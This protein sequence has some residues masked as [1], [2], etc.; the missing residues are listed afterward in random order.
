MCHWSLAIITIITR[1]FIYISTFCDHF[2]VLNYTFCAPRTIPSSARFTISVPLFNAPLCSPETGFLSNFELF[3]LSI[4]SHSRF[5]SLVWSAKKKCW[6]A[7]VG[8]I[9]WPSWWGGRG[10]VL[11]NRLACPSTR[12]LKLGENPTIQRSIGKTVLPPCQAGIEF[13]FSLSQADLRYYL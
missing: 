3:G 5:N 6:G 9:W 10:F 4:L 1:R 7:G 8:Q 13:N 12:S 2:A 11:D